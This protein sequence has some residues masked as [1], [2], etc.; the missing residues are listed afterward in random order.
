MSLFQVTSRPIDVGLLSI[1][2][3][4]FPVISSPTYVSLP[5]IEEQKNQTLQFRPSWPVTNKMLKSAIT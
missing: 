3:L 4:K 5:P 1:E 2:G